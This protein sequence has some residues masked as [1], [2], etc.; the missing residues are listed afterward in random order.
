MTTRPAHGIFT[1]VGLGLPTLVSWRA[2]RELAELCAKRY[3]RHHDSVYI[4]DITI[5]SD[6]QDLQ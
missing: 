2:T 3:R 5:H 1:Q 4:Y 6:R